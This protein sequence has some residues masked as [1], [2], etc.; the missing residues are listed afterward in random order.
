L[1]EEKVSWQTKAPAVDIPRAL[2]TFEKCN[3]NRLDR[4]IV[5]WR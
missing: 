4:N 3:C 2:T 1:A 5:S